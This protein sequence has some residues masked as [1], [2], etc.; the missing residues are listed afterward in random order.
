MRTAPKVIM[1]SPMEAILSNWSKAYAVLEYLKTRSKIILLALQGLDNREIAKKLSLHYNTVSLWRNRFVAEY[2][3]L[4]VVENKNPDELKQELEIV[5]SDMPR[6]GAPLEYDNTVRLKIKLLACQNPKDY[7]FEASH[8][9]LPILQMAVINSGI[10]KEI[11]TGCIYNILKKADIKPWKIRYYLHSKEKYED[12]AT[13]SAKIKAINELYKSAPDLFDKNVLVYS[14]DEMTGIQALQDAA[15]RKPVIPG[16]AE[17]REFNYIR[18]GTT[19]LIGFFCVQTGKLEDPYLKQ[20]RT[21]T[22][23]VEAL[24]RV[25][26]LNPDKEHAFVLDNLNIHMSESL[27]RYVAEKI[28][29]E[30]DL[31]EKGKRGIL[32]S[33]ETRAEFLSDTTHKIRFYYVPIHCS[34]MNQI[35]IWFSVINRR[36]LKRSSY[37]NVEELEASIREYIKQYNELFAHPYNW[38]YDSVPEIKSVDIEK[39]VLGNG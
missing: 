35:E 26:D 34:W 39:S 18:N 29:F 37:E 33:K 5:L 6:S 7:G 38:K 25:I 14:T 15:E 27:V 30:G 21:E 19:S 8:W 36:L 2:P 3:R 32:K 31:G 16:S 9:S 12:Y 4:S 13:Y 28:G 23:F 1:T 17:K 22:D 11:S 24:S 10:V 20:T